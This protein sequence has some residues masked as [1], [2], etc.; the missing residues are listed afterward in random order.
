[1][2]ILTGANASVKRRGRPAA[3]KHSLFANVVPVSSGNNRTYPTRKR[4]VGYV[5]DLS[6]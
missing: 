5:S 4:L 2:M 1:M 6:D 3:G